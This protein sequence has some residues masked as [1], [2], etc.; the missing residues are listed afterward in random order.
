MP[1]SLALPLPRRQIRHA[2]KKGPAWRG[3]IWREGKEKGRSC[4]EGEQKGEPAEGRSHNEKRRGR[5]KGLCQGWSLVFLPSLPPFFLPY[6]GVLRKRRE[7]WRGAEEF[8]PS[9]PPFPSSFPQSYEAKRAEKRARG[10]RRKLSSPQRRERELEGKGQ[11][12]IWQC[13]YHKVRQGREGKGENEVGGSRSETK[14]KRRSLLF[15]AGCRR[16]VGS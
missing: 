8:F 7:V 14:V 5:K 3:R 9:S 11:F 2:L 15:L 1:I 16:S 10:R 4:K 6:H 12:H 13:G